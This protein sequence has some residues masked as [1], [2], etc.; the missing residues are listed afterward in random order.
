[1]SQPSIFMTQLTYL[2]KNKF[3]M[4]QMWLNGLKILLG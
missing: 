4:S 2:F 3:K 1:M